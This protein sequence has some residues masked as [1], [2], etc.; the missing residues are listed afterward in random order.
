MKVEHL[1]KKKKQENYTDTF[2]NFL[3]VYANKSIFYNTDRKINILSEKLQG[4]Q[5]GGAYV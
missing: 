2:N 5:L 1:I 4:F 3:T